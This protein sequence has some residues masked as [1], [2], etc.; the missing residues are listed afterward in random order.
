MILGEGIILRSLLVFFNWI[1]KIIKFKLKVKKYIY[2]E[3]KFKFTLSI[4]Y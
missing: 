2:I 4:Q 3:L 1:L